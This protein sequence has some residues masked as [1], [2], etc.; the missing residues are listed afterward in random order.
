ML[1]QCLA[2]EKQVAPSIAKSNKKMTSETEVKFGTLKRK[3]SKLKLRNPEKESS[4]PK[5]KQV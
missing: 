5:E 3:K 2:V 1:G 4:N